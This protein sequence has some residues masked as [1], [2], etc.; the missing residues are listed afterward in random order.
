MKAQT[1]IAAATIAAVSGPAWAGY[2][3]TQAPTAPSYLGMTLNFDEPGGPT[4]IVTPDAWLV[5][6][7]L[8]IQAGDGTPWVDDWAT[9]TGQPWL[10][11]ANSFYG[12][13]G[14]FMNFESDLAALSLEVWD[15]SGPPSPFG[16]GLYV[17]LFDDGVQVAFGEYTPAWGGI[18]DTW[19][20][21]T[22]NG[23][24]VFD[25]VRILGFGFNPT[26][27][28]DNLSWDVVPGPGSLALLAVAGL[29]S[30]RRRRA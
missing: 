15:P 29:V 27:Y 8:T 19:Y 30:R 16:G 5:S 14:V 7:G 24:D 21:I 17:Y 13:F 6:H 3:I 9:I 28:A 22:A 25:E 4:G 12:N 26:T 1:I 10:G 23:G 20:D 18:G 11:D 2:A